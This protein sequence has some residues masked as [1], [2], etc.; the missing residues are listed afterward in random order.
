MI[1]EKRGGKLARE[2]ANGEGERERWFGEKGR[3][4]S[5]K[6]ENERVTEIAAGVEPATPVYGDKPRSKLV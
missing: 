1:F 4:E 5:S 2:D 6:M 3:H